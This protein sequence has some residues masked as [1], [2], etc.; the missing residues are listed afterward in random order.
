MKKTIFTI[1]ASAA[2]LLGADAEAKNLK[3]AQFTTTPEV[4]CHNC[5]E[6][7]RSNMRFEKGVSDII[8]DLETKIV[9]I[10]YDADKTDTDK[11]IKGFAKIKYEAR[12]KSDA[13]VKEGK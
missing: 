9:T 12:L 5:V 4:H 2:V 11:L 7:I 10:K 8:V 3:T 1:L 13:S 6:K